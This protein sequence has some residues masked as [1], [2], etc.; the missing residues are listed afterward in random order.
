VEQ[1]QKLLK[2]RILVPRDLDARV[3]VFVAA[4][5]VVVWS[6]AIIA[7]SRYFPFVALALIVAA[8]LVLMPRSPRDYYGG[9]AMTALAVIAIWAGGDL[10]GM[11]GFAF[12]PGTAPRLFAGLLI[13]VSTTIALSGV[14]VDGPALEGFAVRG[15]TLVVIAIL[16]FAAMIRPLG[17]VAASYATFMISIIASCVMR[18]VESLIAAAVMTAFCVGLF[19][20]LLQLPFQ[21]WPWFL[22]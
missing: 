4:I 12:G 8:S 10:S 16:A 9:L 21:L 17:L 3:L 6:G 5:A 1:A 13:F 15:P 14:L 11:H 20:Y 7:I 19:V 22:I 18:W 2:L